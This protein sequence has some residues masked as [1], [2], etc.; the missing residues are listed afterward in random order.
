MSAVSAGLLLYRRH[1]RLELFLVHMGGPFFTRR[2]DSWTIPKGLVEEGEDLLSAA[3]REF[4]E[5]TGFAVEDVATGE[6]TKLEPVTQKSGKRVHA[7][8]VE[9]D[10]DPDRMT[11]NTFWAEWPPDSGRQ[12]EFPEAD[13]AGWFTPDQAR[14]I[15]LRGQDGLVDQILERLGLP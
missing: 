12:A 9:G 5:E 1:H 8:A 10:A 13:K 6:F 4:E 2:K 3:R 15:L 7:F 14:D 11:S